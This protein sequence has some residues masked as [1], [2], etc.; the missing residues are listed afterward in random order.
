MTVPRVESRLPPRVAANGLCQATPEA[1]G[2]SS[3]HFVLVSHLISPLPEPDQARRRPV[4]APSVGPTRTRGWDY[5][6]I[7][8]YRWTFTS[9]TDDGFAPIQ[10]AQLK[11]QRKDPGEPRRCSWRPPVASGVVPWKARPDQ[12]LSVPGRAEPG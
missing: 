1:H 11:R 4:R 3:E 7:D 8:E 2:P 5:V 9:P 10:T 12:E 6:N